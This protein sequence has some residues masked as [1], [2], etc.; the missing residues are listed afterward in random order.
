MSDEKPT[1]VLEN[2]FITVWEFR[3]LRIIGNRADNPA[4]GFLYFD[5]HD[6]VFA[7]K[8]LS[9]FKTIGAAKKFIVERETV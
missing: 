9:R 1:V 3:G 8:A 4:D 7:S 5:V 6:K 2:E